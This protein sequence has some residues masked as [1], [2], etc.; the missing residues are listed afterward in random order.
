M[1]KRHDQVLN[2]GLHN[3]IQL[4]NQNPDNRVFVNNYNRMKKEVVDSKI[5]QIKENFLK[6]MRNTSCRVKNQ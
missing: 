4:L 3:A 2:G 5:K 6:V 1:Q